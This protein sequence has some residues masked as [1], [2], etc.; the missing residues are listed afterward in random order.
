MAVGSI[1]GMSIGP[2]TAKPHAASSRMRTASNVIT[3][4]PV[5]EPVAGVAAEAGQH[6]G[7][8][9]QQDERDDRPDLLDRTR[10]ALEHVAP[11]RVFERVDEHA[12]PHPGKGAQGSEHASNPVE[13]HRRALVAADEVDEEL[14]ETH[15]GAAVTARAGRSPGTN[16]RHRALRH[17]PAL[18]D[19]ADVRREPLDDLEDVRGEEDGAAA[20]SRTT[21]GDP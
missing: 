15:I 5:G 19:D 3:G 1:D 17:E 21:A 13:R 9:Y 14:F 2:I 10:Q 12:P 11:T 18:D 16:L 4:S 8:R 6:D 20:A 7:R